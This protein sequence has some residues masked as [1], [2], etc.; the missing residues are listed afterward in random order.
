MTAY[1]ILEEGPEALPEA[2]PETNPVAETWKSS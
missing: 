1:N 2:L